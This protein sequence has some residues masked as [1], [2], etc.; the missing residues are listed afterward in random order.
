MRRQKQSVGR[1]RSKVRGEDKVR[2]RTGV[3]V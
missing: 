2:A 3:D 1:V